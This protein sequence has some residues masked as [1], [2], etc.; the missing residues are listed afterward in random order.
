MHRPFRLAVPVML[1]AALSG[2]ESTSF[3]STGDVSLYWS[4]PL[5]RVN[6]DSL[7][8]TDIMGYEI[9]YWYRGDEQYE[10]VF[11]DGYSI[12]SYH[13]D[14]LPNV[15]EVTF[16]IAVVDSNGLYSE[17]VAAK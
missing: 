12:D 13:F 8:L 5:E 2:C 15:Q 16:K 10:R 6:G 9:R 3:G 11:I 4:P 14:D 17:F 1:A 7:E